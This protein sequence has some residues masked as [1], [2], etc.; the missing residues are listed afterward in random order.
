MGDSR[1]KPGGQALRRAKR[2]A[3][4]I[5]VATLL[6]T[7]LA[8]R[9]V[10]AKR[11]QEVAVREA[12]EQVQTEEDLAYSRYL[13][14]YVA[15]SELGDSLA[16]SCNPLPREDWEREWRMREPV[17]K[18]T[19]KPAWKENTALLERLKEMEEY[20]AQLEPEE[21][22]GDPKKWR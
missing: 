3:A 4:V 2:A 1:G 8:Y 16:T 19:S 6:L 14:G 13:D 5:A 9:L 17:A 10:V 20:E 7:V 12:Q 21:K 11:A 18:Y 22:E 15:C